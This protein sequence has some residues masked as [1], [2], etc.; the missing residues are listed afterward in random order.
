MMNKGLYGEAKGLYEKCLKGVHKTD[1]YIMFGLAQAE[2]ELG[3]FL[4]SRTLLD[5]LIKHNP[6]FKNPDTH[7]LYA[8]ALESLGNISEALH[9]YEVLHQYYPGPEATCRYADLCKVKGNVDLANQL[10]G[11]I[12]KKAQFSGSHYGVLHKKWI[13]IA[14]S[15]IRS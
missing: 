2:F 14:K 15:E 6:E 13:K 8:R 10:Y 7:L 3:N 9:E 5:E 4:A 11:E 1:P 12:L